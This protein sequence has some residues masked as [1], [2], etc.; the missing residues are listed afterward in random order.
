L[1]ALTVLTSWFG[2]GVSLVNDWVAE[3]AVVDISAGARCSGAFSSLQP[4]ALAVSSANPTPV[5]RAKSARATTCCRFGM[6]VTK[7]RTTFIECRLSPRQNKSRIAGCALLRCVQ[8]PL[9]A[10]FIVIFGSSSCRAAWGWSELSGDVHDPAALAPVQKPR[11]HLA[12]DL[13]GK[14]SAVRCRFACGLERDALAQLLEERHGCRRELAIAKAQ[15]SVTIKNQVLGVR[16][17]D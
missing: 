1:G 15:V 12:F 5:N 14:F 17:G 6:G 10:H 2:S 7:R 9:R 11:P 8:R 16:F 13:L 3:L 4:E